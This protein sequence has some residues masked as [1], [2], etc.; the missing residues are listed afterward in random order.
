MKLKD[1]SAEL[2][3]LDDLEKLAFNEKLHGYTDSGESRERLLLLADEL[4]L[5]VSEEFHS[6]AEDFEKRKL[7]L[8]FAKFLGNRI[9]YCSVQRDRVA[10]VDRIEIL[11]PCGLH[12]NIRVPSN[13]LTHLRKQINNRGDFTPLQR[14]LL[15]ERLEEAI[16]QSI[17]SGTN[18]SFNYTYKGTMLQVVSLS[19]VK[20]VQVMDNWAAIVDIAFADLSNPDE[21]ELKGKWC[22]LGERFVDCM[23]LMNY[24]YDMEPSEVDRFQLCMDLFTYRYRELLGIDAETNYVQNMSSGVFRY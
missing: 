5:G 21:L 6:I 8:L 16:N 22:D 23:L 24:K 4:H 20:L 3:E 13:L 2:G 7:L 14:K 12:N 15:G 11:I 17:G 9:E 10:I 1:S 19:G 18:A